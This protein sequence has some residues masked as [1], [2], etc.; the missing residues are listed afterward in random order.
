MKWERREIQ[1]PKCLNGLFFGTIFWYKRWFDCFWN[2][3]LAFLCTEQEKT[4]NQSYKNGKHKH[5]DFDFYILKFRRKKIELL[6]F[7]SDWSIRSLVHNHCGSFFIG[8]KL[9][10]FVSEILSRFRYRHGCCRQRRCFTLAKILATSTNCTSTTTWCEF[11]H[12][13]IFH[14]K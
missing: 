11:G 3:S 13:N 5:S 8:K 1:Q 14:F 4:K 10:L 2:H 6:G 12:I 9:C 7:A